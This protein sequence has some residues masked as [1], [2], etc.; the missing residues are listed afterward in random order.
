MAIEPLRPLPPSPFGIVATIEVFSH[1]LRVSQYTRNA[2]PVLY[3]FCR[4]LAEWG[5]VKTGPRQF[6]RGM[7]KVF[8][9][10]AKDRSF[11]HFHRHQLDALL[12]HFQSQ[13]IGPTQLR[14]IRHDLYK[15]L[16]VPFRYHDPRTPREDQAPIIDYVVAE[17]RT[18]VVTLPPGKGKTFIALKAIHRLGV[19][20]F[21][22]IQ[23]KYQK[24]WIIDAKEAFDLRKKDIITVKGSKQLKQL[25]ELALCGELEAQIIICSNKTFQ[26]YLKAYEAHSGYLDETGYG[27]HPFDFYETLGVGLKVVDEVH[28]SFHLNF[29]QDVYTHVHK[30]LSLS[31]TLQSDDAFINKVTSIMFPIGERYKMDEHNEHTVARALL[32]SINDVERRVSYINPALQMYSHVRFEQSIM[33]RKTLLKG[34]LK[35]V[36]DI[37]LEEYLAR[38]HPK[39]KCLIFFSTVEMVEHALEYFKSLNTGV[40]LTRYVQGDDYEEM[41]KSEVI[42]S[43]LKSCGTAVDIPDLFVVLMTD[44]LGSRQANLQAIGRLREMKQYPNVDPEFIYL[45]CSN[46]E[47]HVEYHRKKEDIFTGQVIAHRE[48]YTPYIL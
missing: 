13:G 10:A 6:S 18:K 43:T 48:E 47:K 41:L 3:R 37:F 16:A 4:T 33:K 28:E 44:A 30:T 20:T 32:Y 38:R 14:L 25:I 12:Q 24:K 29:R 46:I 22:C 35:M 39:H 17:G 19:R 11:F 9:G 34:Y 27:C 1:G 7:I 26:M 15:P 36:G 8:A 5:L 45:V 21:F 42:I 23:P 2:G 40:R 31:G